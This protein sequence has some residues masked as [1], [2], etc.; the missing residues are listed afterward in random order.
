MELKAFFPSSE[1]GPSSSS[2]TSTI[3]IPERLGG[4]EKLFPGRRSVCR[5]QS[6]DRVLGLPELGVSCPTAL[7]RGLSS[8]LQS[9]SFPNRN[10]PRART[11]PRLFLPC[12]VPAAF[13]VPPTARNRERRRGRGRLGRGRAPPGKAT[14]PEA[15]PRGVTLASS[16][17]C[18]VLVSQDGELVA[19][20]ALGACA[21]IGGDSEIVGRAA[22]GQGHRSG[23][24]IT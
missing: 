8:L 2:R 12:H 11:R 6:M 19:D 5:S 9:L 24:V 4:A 20:G 17:S 1:K 16:F 18:K 15:A 14:T 23:G 22:L 21:V 13:L 3:T 10:R 7:N